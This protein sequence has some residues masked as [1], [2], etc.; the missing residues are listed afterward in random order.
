MKQYFYQ[1]ITF[2]NGVKE[3]IVFESKEDRSDYVKLLESENVD[4]LFFNNLTDEQFL[5]LKK[6]SQDM[7]LV[8][9]KRTTNISEIREQVKSYLGE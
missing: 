6:E 9:A 5:E 8:K 1:L 4:S 7:I 3:N 2:H